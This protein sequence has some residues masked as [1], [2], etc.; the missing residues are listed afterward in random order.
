MKAL[1]LENMLEENK[2]KLLTIINMINKKYEIY[3]KHFGSPQERSEKQKKLL[4]FNKDLESKQAELFKSSGFAY[5]KIKDDKDKLLESKKRLL[6]KFKKN[7][8]SRENLEKKIHT[9]FTQ[10]SKKKSKKTIK[11]IKENVSVL[12]FSHHN[13]SKNIETKYEQIKEKYA[14]DFPSLYPTEKYIEK[15]QGEIT[16]DIELEFEISTQLT[17]IEYLHKVKSRIQEKIKQVEQ[18]IKFYEKQ[19]NKI[20]EKISK[21]QNSLK[22]YLEEKF[23]SR[24]DLAK[25]QKWPEKSGFIS[26]LLFEH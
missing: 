3:A 22:E 8:P 1:R 14:K 26:R 25:K 6:D 20:S 2:K 17:S 12:K 5:K 21:Q 10:L 16:G 13:I 9:G 23:K 19:E 11:E 4:L 18:N 24:L 15:K 7:Y